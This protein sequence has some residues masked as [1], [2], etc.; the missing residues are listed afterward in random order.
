M[1]LTFGKH[2]GKT[3]EEVAAI[4]HSNN[5]K[6]GGKGY[7]KWLQ[8]NTDDDALR[9]AIS[10][11]VGASTSAP[12]ARS[13]QSSKPAERYTEAEKRVF[14]AKDLVGIMQTSVNAAATT[15]AGMATAKLFKDVKEAKAFF[16]KQVTENNLTINAVRTEALLGD[17]KKDEGSKKDDSF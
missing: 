2:Q 7:L 3:L 9:N 5:D 6:G 4:P 14:E 10:S 12:A 1:E 13:S 16:D 8:T 17:S 15:T 11:V